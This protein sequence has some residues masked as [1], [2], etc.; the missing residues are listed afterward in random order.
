MA[1]KDTVF[2]KQKMKRF[3]NLFIYETTNFDG[4]FRNCK[5]LEDVPSES[6]FIYAFAGDVFTAINVDFEN[7]EIFFFEEFDDHVPIFT[8]PFNIN[9]K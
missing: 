2:K 4:R 7:S 8:I 5:L 6:G 9:Y 3:A 1:E